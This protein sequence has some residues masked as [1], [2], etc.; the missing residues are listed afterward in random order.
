MTAQKC[1]YYELIA[2][3]SECIENA[4]FTIPWIM[5]KYIVTCREVRLKKIKGSRSDIGFIGT[6]VTSSL[7]HTQL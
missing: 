3:V 5:Y 7:N 2:R 6:S 4:I 1:H